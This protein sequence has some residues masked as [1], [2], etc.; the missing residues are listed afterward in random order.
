MKPEFRDR[1]GQAIVNFYVFANIAVWVGWNTWQTWVAGQMGYVEAAFALQS[2]VMLTLILVRRRHAGLDANPLH[3]AVAAVAFYSGLAFLG[4]PATADGRVA[5]VG[6][7][8]TLAANLLSMAALLNLGRSFGILIAR[9]PLRT[10]GLYAVVRHPMYAS[11]ILLR[12]GFVIGH[13]TA[14]TVALLVASGACYVYR[15]LLEERFLAREEAYRAYMRRVRY[16]LVPF[17]F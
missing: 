13:C 17:V 2:L 1:F 8:V 10:G 14:V 7:G 15:A 4:Q 6:R 16:R 3:Q 12:V 11:D 9:R 5:L